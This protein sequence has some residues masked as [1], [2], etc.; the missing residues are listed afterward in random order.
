MTASEIKTAIENGTKEFVS[1]SKQAKYTIK[2]LSIIKWWRADIT[3]IRSGNHKGVCVGNTL[4]TF[5]NDLSKTRDIKPFTESDLTTS[6]K[7][8]DFAEVDYSITPS[9][10]LEM[11]QLANKGYQAAMFE[12]DTLIIQFYKGN[13]TKTFEFP[14]C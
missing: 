5:C 7:A 13:E 10:M 8:E 12:N 2:K 11:I 6:I 9:E 14:H 3:D 1:V 4:E